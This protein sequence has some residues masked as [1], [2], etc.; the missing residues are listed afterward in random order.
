MVNINLLLSIVYK[1]PFCVCISKAKLLKTK[2]LAKNVKKPVILV[3]WEGALHLI[4]AR[5]VMPNW[6]AAMY[7]LCTKACAQCAHACT[8][9][10]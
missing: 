4:L 9:C 2:G 7:T 3:V 5:H 6:A 10:T 8:T 1:S